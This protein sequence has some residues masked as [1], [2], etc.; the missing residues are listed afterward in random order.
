[1]AN[2]K[3]VTDSSAQ[4][5]PEEIQKFDITVVHLSVMI[6]GETF[7]D[8]KKISND[9]FVKLM[10]QSKKLPTTSQPPVGKFVDAFNQLGQAGN[11]VVCITMMNQLSGTFHSAQSAAQQSDTDVS[12]V[13]SQSTDR[14][15]AFQVLNAAQLA[16]SGADVAEI[17]AKV[18]KVREHTHLE[19][20]VMTLDNIVK[21]GRLNPVAG[22]I[23]NFLKIKIILEIQQ[24]QDKGQLKVAA[25]GR[26]IK[27]VKKYFNNV[28][29]GMKNMNDLKMIGLSYVSPTKLID[30]ITSDLR[31]SF[32]NVPLLY[33]VTTPIIATHAG[34]GA[35]AL[36]YYDDPD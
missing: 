21:G 9:Q 3:I 34:Q 2:V 33:R 6:D 30:E 5:T 13:D 25:K 26:G 8:H 20:G 11:K 36:I 10:L 14:G 22:A 17:L 32:P 15:L 24:G 7:D 16:L 4:L 29:A 12:V 19:M 31:V 35:F 18:K 27:F 23:T 28:I 1:M